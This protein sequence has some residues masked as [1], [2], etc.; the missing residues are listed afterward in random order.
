MASPEPARSERAPPRAPAHTELVVPALSTSAGI[1]YASGAIGM[2]LF[3]NF[4]ASWQLYYFAPPADTGR[5]VYASVIAIS[6]VNLV[7]QLAHALADGY[8]GHASDRTRSRWGRRLPWI[9][10]SS[11]IC[12]LA[13]IAIW[14]P[15]SAGTSWVN[16]AW[17][18]ALR[19]IMW[20]AYT[21]VYGPYSALLAEITRGR[22]RIRISVFMALF[23]VFGIVLATSVAG[24]I[25]EGAHDGLRVGPL[26]LSDGFKVAA[27][28]T[29]LFALAGIGSALFAVTETPHHPS[30]EVPFTLLQAVRQT[31]RNPAFVWYAVAFV[32]F[33]VSLAAVITMIPY[34]VSVVMGLDRA[35]GIAGSLQ[36]VVVLGAV[37]FFPLV[38]RLARRY[39]KKRIMLSGFVG[40]S[41]VMMASALV[42]RLGY[43]STLVQA[44]AIYALSTFPVATLLVLSRPILA[45]V[46]DHDQTLTGYRREGIYQGVEGLVLKL[47]E[48]VGPVVAAGMFAWLG[49]TRAAPLGVMLTGPV[50]GLLCLVG[51]AFFRKYPLSA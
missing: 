17:L 48:G 7:G 39:G 12:A 3:P 51:W 5:I 8:I 9:A 50:A 40:F 30:K 32:A 25:I 28:V 41:L 31:F 24:S 29:S 35:E 26:F 11:P 22:M 4:L 34:Q 49:S 21:G 20:F 16:V 15:P 2:S 46:I 23:E 37:L 19:A 45:D 27:I 10:V 33:R 6:I 14:W 47:A 43:A 42:G 1:A 18:V 44:Y 38:D 36:T 13:F